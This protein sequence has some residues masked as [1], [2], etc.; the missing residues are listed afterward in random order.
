MEPLPKKTKME[1]EEDFSCKAKVACFKTFKSKK[2]LQ[3]HVKCK[4]PF[5]QRP[6]TPPASL[7]P[8]NSEFMKTSTQTQTEPVARAGIDFVDDDPEAWYNYH[9]MKEE[10]LNDRTVFSTTPKLDEMSRELSCPV[11]GEQQ[12][13]RNL[14]IIVKFFAHWS[15]D[16]VETR[17][18]DSVTQLLIKHSRSVK[19]ND[20]NYLAITISAIDILHRMGQLHLQTLLEL[21]YNYIATV[22][23]KKRDHLFDW[24][25]LIIVFTAAHELLMRYPH[26]YP[27]LVDMLCEVFNHAGNDLDALGGW[28]DFKSYSG[29]FFMQL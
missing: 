26:L 13:K 29:Q 9:R 20:G 25:C 5:C 7:G 3:R 1:C 28:N 4:H 19:Q 23:G 16:K 22:R 27:D 18:I 2:G 14:D 6:S 12:R 11:N 21:I 24:D 10:P 8:N 15:D 17:A